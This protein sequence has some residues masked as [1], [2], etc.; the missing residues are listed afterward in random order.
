[1]CNRLRE[2]VALAQRGTRVFEF[3]A[4]FDVASTAETDES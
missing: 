1:V 4:R 3:T 2:L